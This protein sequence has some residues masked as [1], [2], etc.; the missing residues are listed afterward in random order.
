MA[1]TADS[2]AADVHPDPALLWFTSSLA[3]ATALFGSDESA[4]IHGA[5]DS[6]SKTAFIGVVIR[7]HLLE[8]MMG[9]ISPSLA[10]F[11]RE[12]PDH[13]VG[14]TTGQF[15]VVTVAAP[16]TVLDEG[17]G[18]VD[19]SVVSAF[20]VSASHPA[21]MEVVK[22]EKAE[23]EEKKKEKSAKK[24]KECNCIIH[25]MKRAAEAAAKEDPEKDS[26]KD[27][28]LRFQ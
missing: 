8:Y 23:D 18:P 13:K 26:K 24:D 20:G 6:L 5:F 14:I 7:M 3:K 2:L 27:D 21:F 12:F 22:K 4:H 9:L 17:T 25:Q 15:I 11:K 1:S 19:R 10:A 28:D 16:G